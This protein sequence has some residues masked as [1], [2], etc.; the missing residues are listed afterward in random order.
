MATRTLQSLNLMKNVMVFSRLILLRQL[1]IITRLPVIQGVKELADMGL[2]PEGAYRNQAAYKKFVDVNSENI[3]RS[4][5]DLLYDAQTSGGLLLAVSPE[6]SDALLT[7]IRQQN[8]EHAIIIGEFKTGTG[9]IK[10]F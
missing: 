7:H 4:N 2:V 3:N 10:I 8:F 6:K 9:R 5:I 1:L